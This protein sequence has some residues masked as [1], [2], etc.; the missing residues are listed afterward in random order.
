MMKH[1][2]MQRRSTLV[3]TGIWTAAVLALL[4]AG[5]LTFFG[6]ASE[7]TE[8]KGAKTEKYTPVTEKVPETEDAGLFDRIFPP[9]VTEN[10]ETEA[11]APAVPAVPSAPALTSDSPAEPEEPFAVDEAP[12]AY[13]PGSGA[14]SCV[15]PV[16]GSVSKGFTEDIA[17]Y[18][19]TMN[20]Y[21]VHSGIDIDVPVGT[22]V[23]ACA[24]GTVERVWDDPFS[25]T[26][27]LIDHGG[28]MKSLYANLSP[29]LPRG[30]EAGMTVNAGDVIGGVGETMIIEMADSSHLHF[31][32]QE[33]GVYVDPLSYIT[34]YRGNA[35][36]V[37][38]E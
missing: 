16:N 32:M 1:Q 8:N 7:K 6:A 26:S 11:P 37:Y 13:Y 14:F 18:S 34:N 23:C 24:A 5:L 17:V 38:D 15:M 22:N 36:L 27:I 10:E 12:A 20:D 25:G 35:D 28:N 4:G 2:P 21:R 9:A 19:L 29:E 30:V 3:S 31:A 33:G